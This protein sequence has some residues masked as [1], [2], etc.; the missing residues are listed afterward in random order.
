MYTSICVYIYTHTFSSIF[1]DVSVKPLNFFF[2]GFFQHL[3]H[4][5]QR[6]RSA[7]SLAFGK[8]L[9]IPWSP[10]RCVPHPFP[11]HMFKKKKTIHLCS[12]AVSH[13]FT[14]E[15]Y[16]FLCRAFG[17]NSYITATGRT[18]VLALMVGVGGGG[19]WQW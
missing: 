11:L 5:A 19:C 12:S 17:E 18:P 10:I 1:I 9:G 2:S 3:R 8:A 13:V 15:E 14:F 6:R 7:P 16:S 4:L